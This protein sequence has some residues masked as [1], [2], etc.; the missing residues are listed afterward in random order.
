VRTWLV[1]LTPLICGAQTLRVHAPQGAVG[2]VTAASVVIRA[3]PG[4]TVPAK[5][6]LAKGDRVLVL[7]EVTGAWCQIVTPAGGLGFVP[8]SALNRTP[9]LALVPGVSEIRAEAD[10]VVIRVETRRSEKRETVAPGIAYVERQ[11]TRDGDGPFTMQVLEV[12]PTDAAVNLLPVRAK[13]HAAGKETVSSMAHRYG[14]TAAIN[15]GYFAVGGAYAGASAGVYLWNGQVLSGG[16]G[17]TA[18]LFCEETNDRERLVFSRV[19]FQGSASGADGARTPILGVNRERAATDDLVAYRSSFGPRTLTGSGGVEAVLDA[20]GLVLR[21]EDEAGGASIPEAG[22][23]LSGTGT[24]AD[25]LR[26]NAKPGA[27]LELDLTLRTASEAGCRPTD[28]TGGG[29]RLVEEGRMSA[30]WEGFGHAHARNPRT[31][32]AVTS[33]GTLL[34]VTLDGRQPGSAGMRLD[35]F[36]RELV[37]LGAVDAMNLDGGGSTTM[38]A[39]GAVRNSPSDGAERPVSDAVLVYSI[40]DEKALQALRE[41]LD[42]PGLGWAKER[43]LPEAGRGVAAASRGR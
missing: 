14:A 36:A 7:D 25:W 10:W 40:P 11:W 8:C 33:R 27:R 38:V 30:N 1:L 13:D 2:E 15:G 26:Q 37:A 3:G 17:R 42:S 39:G 32:V 20:K 23:V 21:L 43:L 31:A 22:T 12:D 6:Y 5:A 28:I 18:L 9:G 35:E 4:S 16:A 41:V 34:F 24:G 29:P 19:D